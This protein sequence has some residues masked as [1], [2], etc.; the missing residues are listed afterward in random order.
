MDCLLATRSAGKIREIREL[1]Q[2]IPRLELLGLDEAAV[3]YSSAEDEVERF[4]TFLDNARAKA[5]YF[6]DRTGLPTIA[7]D[8]GIAVAALFGAPGVRSK[9]FAADAGLTS[10]AEAGDLD[11]LNNEL[12][13]MRMRDLPDERRA[14]HYACIAALAIPGKIAL[15]TIG[16][17]SGMIAHEPR[18]DRGFGYD[19]IFFIPELG[20]TFA[21]V[22][23]TE[24]NR[25]SHRARA[26][27][28]LRAHL[29]SALGI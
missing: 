28:A 16:T 11:R 26:F 9:R 8:S 14:A 27:L 20:A 21:E 10:S 18:G 13:L 12:L 4:D 29:P 24:K 5:L 15:T 6:A 23:A 3:T 25:R 1:L 2:G 7:D 22:P 19:P 17:C